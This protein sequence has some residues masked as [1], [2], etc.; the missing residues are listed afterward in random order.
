MMTSCIFASILVAGDKV[1]VP[2]T[3]NIHKGCTKDTQ[4]K[5]LCT[6]IWREA[7]QLLKW[8]TDT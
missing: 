2:I 4:C 7:V 6:I 5:L 8:F 1:V 3:G